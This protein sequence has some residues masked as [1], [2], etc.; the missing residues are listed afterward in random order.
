MEIRILDGILKL[1]NAI[2]LSPITTSLANST[3]QLSSNQSTITNNLNTNSSSSQTALSILINNFEP[4]KCDDASK[5]TALG[6]AIAAAVISNKSTNENSISNSSSNS[7]NTTDNSAES[8]HIFQILTAC[9]CLF[10]SH[11]KIA[12]YLEN[13]NEIENMNKKIS[14]NDS[15]EDDENNENINISDENDVNTNQNEVSIKSLGSND[16]S[17]VSDSCKLM[18]SDLRVPLSWKWNDYIKAS[19]NSGK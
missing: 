10:V 18:L 16:S 14:L 13:L 4:A 8:N 17:L 7:S 3:L 5:C 9:K 11:R 15:N 6:A 19:K 1:L 2:C 12:I